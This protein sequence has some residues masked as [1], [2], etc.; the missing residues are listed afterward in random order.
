MGIFQ[1]ENPNVCYLEPRRG[2]NRGNRGNGGASRDFH[3]RFIS[4]SAKEKPMA[5]L[6]IPPIDSPPFAPVQN[7]PSSMKSA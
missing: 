1:E 2:G 3:P 7:L 4:T 5:R 6:K